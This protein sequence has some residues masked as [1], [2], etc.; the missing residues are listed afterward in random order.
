[1]IFVFSYESGSE[2]IVAFEH[3]TKKNRFGDHD[4]E[5]L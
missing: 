5:E 3:N 2:A 4:V 1:M